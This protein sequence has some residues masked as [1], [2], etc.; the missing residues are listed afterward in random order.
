MCVSED[1]GCFGRGTSGQLALIASSF[2]AFYMFIAKQKSDF[3][4][5]GMVEVD[6]GENM[7]GQVSASQIHAF[8]NTDS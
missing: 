2:Y 6:E 7:A 3:A 5:C 8:R 4:L 1:A